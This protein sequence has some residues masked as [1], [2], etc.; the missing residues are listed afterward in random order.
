MTTP[1]PQQ[2]QI[3]NLL[4]NIEIDRQI[5][6]VEHYASECRKAMALSQAAAKEA[7]RASPL[8]AANAQGQAIG[9]DQKSAAAQEAGQMSLLARESMGNLQLACH[10]LLGLFAPPPAAGPKLVA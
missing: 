1:D 10:R 8:V 4:K 6:L 3:A 2:V 9:P 7:Q 5:T